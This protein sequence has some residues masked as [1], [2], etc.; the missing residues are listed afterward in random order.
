MD[1]IDKSCALQ[2]ERMSQK[3]Y[4]YNIKK[5]A[6]KGNVK[7]VPFFDGLPEKNKKGLSFFFPSRK[8]ALFQITQPNR[9]RT[10][11]KKEKK[12]IAITSISIAMA[13]T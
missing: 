1:N 8:L 12:A 11:V 5:K 4:I 13:S 9:D 7:K 3:K 10:Y 6:A 2:N